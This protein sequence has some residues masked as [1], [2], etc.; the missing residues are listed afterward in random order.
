[1]IFKVIFS[2]TC[3]WKWNVLSKYNLSCW[4]VSVKSPSDIQ[5]GCCNSCSIWF[6]SFSFSSNRI[7]PRSLYGSEHCHLR[8]DHSAQIWSKGEDHHSVSWIWLVLKGVYTKQ[9]DISH[10]VAL[11]LVF[12]FVGKIESFNLNT[13]LY[14]QVS[15]TV[16]CLHGHFIVDSRVL[17]LCRVLFTHTLNRL[18][19]AN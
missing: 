3:F 11:S 8:T 13:G 12:A 9:S 4:R 19:C 16:W 1:M 6:T 2:L 5:W 14:W 10:S 18:C 15:V 7:P 17:R